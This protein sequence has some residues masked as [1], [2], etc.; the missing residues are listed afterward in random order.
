MRPQAYSAGSGGWPRAVQ[1]QHSPLAFPH[2]WSGWG[3]DLRLAPE[4][5]AAAAF[6]WNVGLG[7]LG[8]RPSALS[9][10]IRTPP[11][12]LRSSMEAWALPHRLPHTPT[13]RR[14]SSP[15]LDEQPRL[16]RGCPVSESPGVPLRSDGRQGGPKGSSVDTGMSLDGRRLGAG[17]P[18]GPTRDEGGGQFVGRATRLRTPCGAGPRPL[19]RKGAERHDTLVCIHLHCQRLPS[20]SSTPRWRLVPLPL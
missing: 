2:S 7:P 8:P 19:S 11:P 4:A 17:Q 10:E 16:G 5:Q 6:R 20:G 12:P 9:A 14:I 18:S 3:P 15:A 1:R 13:S